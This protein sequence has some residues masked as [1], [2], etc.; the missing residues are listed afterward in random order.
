MVFSLGCQQ[1]V[2]KE[3]AP[4][5]QYSI[6]G[7]EV[8]EE[9]YQVQ[10]PLYIAEKNGAR[11]VYLIKDTLGILHEIDKEE[12][13]TLDILSPAELEKWY[14]DLLQREPSKVKIEVIK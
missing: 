14:G 13:D 8:T 7:V 12:C 1:K 2:I 11:Q 9:E 3:F 5:H 10:S 4:V 6:A